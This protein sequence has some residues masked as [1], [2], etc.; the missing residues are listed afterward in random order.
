MVSKGCVIHS[1]RH[2]FR[3]RFLESKGVFGYRKTYMRQFGNETQS[4]EHKPTR[5]Q[6]K[7]I[8]VIFQRDFEILGY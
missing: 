3:D 4:T 8:E 6:M 2:S 1:F 5:S 7:R